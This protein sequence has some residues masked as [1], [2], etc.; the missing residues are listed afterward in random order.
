MSDN[1]YITREHAELYRAISEY[2]KP[3]VTEE[4]LRFAVMMID[5]YFTFEETTMNEVTDAQGIR[6]ELPRR[7][8]LDLDT[9]EVFNAETDEKI[10]L[11]QEFTLSEWNALR[12]TRTFAK[13]HLSKGSKTMRLDLRLLLILKRAPEKKGAPGGAAPAIAR[14]FAEDLRRRA[15][16]LE[17]ALGIETVLLDIADEWEATDDG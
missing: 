6:M 4:A 15:A 17:V 1:S 9:Q 2:W 11:G 3:P 14:I 16:N 7:L 12:E 13:P 5:R 8:L 10:G